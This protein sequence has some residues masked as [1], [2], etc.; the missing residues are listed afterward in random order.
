VLGVTDGITAVAQG[1]SSEVGGHEIR[2]HVRPPRALDRS[3]LNPSL[4]ILSPL[5][6]EAAQAQV[7]IESRAKE[8]HIN[9]TFVK[10]VSLGLGQY[11]VLTER[12]LYWKNSN[13]NTNNDN[14]N[15]QPLWSRAWIDISHVSFYDSNIDDTTENNN[16]DYKVGIRII[17][18]PSV[19]QTT[20]TS[21]GGKSLLVQTLSHS[22]AI[23]LYRTLAENSWRLG[24][25]T[26]VAP[27]E[28]AASEIINKNIDISDKN[29][30][31]HEIQTTEQEK[32]L[33]IVDNNN[34]EYKKQEYEIWKLLKIR[35]KSAANEW[36]GYYFGSF[37]PHL[38][39]KEKTSRLASSS[40]S[41]N[42][43]RQF[44]FIQYAHTIFNKNKFCKSL[45][46]LESIDA[47]LY[48]LV[49]EWNNISDINNANYSPSKCCALLVLNSSQ[50]SFSLN[51]LKL[52]HGRNCHIL[53]GPHG[54]YESHMRRVLPGGQVV[55]FA[56]AHPSSPLDSGSLRFDLGT[57]AFHA[58]ISTQISELTCSS[59]QGFTVGIVIKT[60]VEWWSR[61][62][63]VVT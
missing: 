2:V 60:C 35:S 1:V 8:L 40:I 5:D 21:T 12:F 55:L 7:I 36:M 10:F 32:Q 17:L 57:T 16:N 47:A 28:I 42:I 23:Q 53:G 24:N 13:S 11:I 44:D 50:S 56:I 58:V 46:V 33:L 14:D 59:R 48:Y 20:F 25:P 34:N 52:V 62:I 27:I 26:K 22:I 31:I 29:D 39:K 3:P 45:R 30:S 49:N 9:D 43:D 19:S 54:G 51:S 63:L 6:L 61:Y 41:S 4:L 38:I 37:S 15:I 18:Y